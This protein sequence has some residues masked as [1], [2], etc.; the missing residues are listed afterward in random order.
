M[1]GFRKKNRF[2]K[3]RGAVVWCVVWCV[4]WLVCS[5][6]AAAR[7]KAGKVD[8]R[9]VAYLEAARR[10][11][12]QNDVALA[13]K[14]L[15]AARKCWQKK[16]QRCGFL[17]VDYLALLGVV[18]LEYGRFR[19][20]A[21]TFR[22]VLRARPEREAIWLYYGQALYQI[23]LYRRA[24]GALAKAEKLGSRSAVY[25]VLRGRA[26]MQAEQ[27]F[28][29]RQ[30]L[31]KGLRRFPRQGA[32]Y[33]ALSFLFARVGL[34]CAAREMARR[35]ADLPQ[36]DLSAYFYV[37]DKLLAQGQARWAARILEEARFTEPDNP[38]VCQRLAL[39]Y[40]RSQRP[41]AAAHLFERAARRKTA[42]VYAA[43]EQYRICQHFRD[44]LRLNRRVA[45][46]RKRYV[47][48]LNILLGAE[49]YGRAV[50]LKKHLIRHGLLTDEVRYRLAYAAIRIGRYDTAKRLLRL[51]RGGA[52]RK[53]AQRLIRL[54][55]P[56][57][58]KPWLC[59]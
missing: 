15:Q 25:F 34:F 6:P 1:P 5:L 12:V 17:K 40:A 8:R 10:A 54:V 50:A 31:E 48:R 39:A 36:G 27:M 38:Q 30:T 18:Y 19:R 45:D 9:R 35:F 3:A 53:M 21:E 29:A 13:V 55:K 59:P 28:A 46:P 22:R 32:L 7:R 44:A 2:W 24:A 49:A 52:Y 58:K 16:K 41:L 4:V 51:I 26:E 57:E 23:G 20:A 43:A 56:C 14:A 47:Q 37:A 42:L 33:R 11:L